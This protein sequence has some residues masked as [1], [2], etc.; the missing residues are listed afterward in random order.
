MGCCIWDPITWDAAPTFPGR[1]CCSQLIHMIAEILSGKY[2]AQPR[3]KEREFHCR[4]ENSFPT[5]RYAVFPLHFIVC[6]NEFF[7]IAEEYGL[8]FFRSND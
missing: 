2:M 8:I 6:I 3:T 5:F 1:E 7:M 4:Y